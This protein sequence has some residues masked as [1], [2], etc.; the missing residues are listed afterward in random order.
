M[1]QLLTGKLGGLTSFQGA[2]SG[3]VDPPL[4]GLDARWRADT[5]VTEAGTGVSSWVDM[6]SSF[7]MVQGTDANR[8]ALVT[9]VVNGQPIIR[10]TQ[11]NTDF[12]TQATGPT[13]QAQ[14]YTIVAVIKLTSTGVAQWTLTASGDGNF[15]SMGSN[16]TT[17]WMFAGSAFDTG[18]VVETTNF[19]SLIG[20]FNG[21]SSEMFL[22]NA[23]L[24][25]GD[26]STGASTTGFTVGGGNSSGANPFGGD[27]AEVL[28]YD[29]ALDS[30]E[31][32]ALDTYFAARYAI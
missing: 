25:T 9:G 31:R 13:G 3:A 21:A 32:T 22:D 15:R 16:G 28:F 6:I 2:Y 4:T 24:G 10:F 1:A 17:A 20:I 12:L 7:D 23:S 26:A 27:I 8:P 30:T 5:G 18:D 11:A 14:P 29:H 19:H